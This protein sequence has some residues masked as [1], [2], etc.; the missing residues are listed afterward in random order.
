M[1]ANMATVHM[2]DNEV[3]SNFAAVLE[4][5]RKGVEVIVEQDNRP[6]ALIRSPHSPRAVC[7]P[8]VL[9]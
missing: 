5:I 3:T 7:C 2:T 9:L 1:L 4:K 6:V 8:S